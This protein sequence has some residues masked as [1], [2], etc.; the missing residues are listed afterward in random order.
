[1]GKH[2]ERVLDLKIEKKWAEI[3]KEHLPIDNTE[4]PK[5]LFGLQEPYELYRKP[6]QK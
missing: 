5:N 3:L 4:E 6:K 2:D 1:M